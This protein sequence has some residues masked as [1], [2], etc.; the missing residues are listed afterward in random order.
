MPKCRIGCPASI[1][2]LFLLSSSPVATAQVGGVVGGTQIVPRDRVPPPRTGTGSVKGRVV[3][4]VSGGPVARARVTLMGSTRAMVVTDA[5]GAFAF[6]NLPPGPINI[7]VDK[8]TYLNTSYPTRGR[9]FRSSMRP[10]MLTDG[11]ALDGVT[12][13]VF[14]GGSISG[15]VVDANGDPVDYAQ[16]GVLRI[17][18]PGRIGNPQMRSGT[19]TDDRGE[20]RIGRLEPGTYIVQAS[21]RRGPNFAEDITP[22]GTG[23]TAPLPLPLPTYYPGALSLDQAQPIAIERGQAAADIE[24]ILAE[25]TPGVIIGTVTM[26]SGTL[27]SDLNTFIN[28]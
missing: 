27:S 14:H 3:D 10:V 6:A 21:A 28:I 13:P 26:N 16:I 1:A 12:I 4:G 8:S 9:T 17:P 20:F 19:S 22:A 24:V 18:A 23:P 5:G 15:R 25:G 7:S 2:F 11:Q